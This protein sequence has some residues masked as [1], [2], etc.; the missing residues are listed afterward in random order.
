[1]AQIKYNDLVLDVPPGQSVLDTLLEHEQD[2]PNNCRA[3]VCQS[4]VM[5]VTRGKVPEQAQHGLKDSQKAKGLFLACSCQPEEDIDISLPESKLLR[6]EASVQQIKQL[7]DGVIELKLTTPE[8]FEYHAGQYVTLW[9]DDHLGRSY[10]LASL[11][12]VDANLTFHIRLIP[13]GEF[14]G[15]VHTQLAVGDTV[16]VQGPVGDCFYT[17]GN[18]EQ[19]LLLIGTG[20]GLAPLYG[21]LR[22]ALNNG[23][24]GEIHLF[25]GVL[26]ASGLYLHDRLTQLEREHANLFYHSCVFHA[27]KDQAE[28]IL[29]GD[30]G[31][32]ALQIVPKPAGWKAFLC[33]DPE[34]VQKLRRK[35]F[36]A[37]CNMN[38]I[39]ADPFLHN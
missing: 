34:L 32:I 10:S 4:C 21:I 19:N 35:V 22:D 30:I 31:D 15:W 13:G 20:T 17:Q 8:P 2:I 11:P 24:Q 29:E 28:N 18:P 7:T 38:D 6:V 16:Y 14:S 23:H 36:L 12:Q 33:G 37:G 9:R 25:H 5:Q 3:G 26:I 39:Y 27:E 1:M